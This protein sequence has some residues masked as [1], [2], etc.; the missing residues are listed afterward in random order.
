M[1]TFEDIKS[2]VD[3]HGD[4]GKY[5][6]TRCI[7]HNDNGPSLL[8]FADG[9]FRCL[10]CN[11]A[12]NWKQLWGKLR[13]QPITISVEKGTQWKGVNTR[14][15]NLEE[16]CYRSH[17]HLQKFDSFAYYIQTRGLVD[18]IDLYEIGYFKGWYTIP[19]RDEQGNFITA[20]F[21]AAPHV[22]EASGM[23]YVTKSAPVMYVPDW[24]L[25]RNSNYLCVVY[26]MFDA[27]T[28]SLLGIPAVTSTGG[29]DL[30]NPEWLDK[31]RKTILV[32]PDKGEEQTAE[33][34]V[35]NL[36]WR[37]KKVTLNYPDGKKDCTGFME[38][39]KGQD[40]YKQILNWRNQYVKDKVSFGRGNKSREWETNPKIEHHVPSFK[41]Q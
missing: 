21:R 32:I 35:R 7:F 24:N 15:L 41:S 5:I 14:N 38:L 10:G 31:I 22:A 26:G 17:L 18:A 6:S 19:V 1:L 2:R 16:L 11:R 30:F 37:G 29:K 23:R 34:L 28:L 3:I 39:G 13:G 12:G 40:L 20:V 36:G 25:V 4:Y 9:W 8:I 33:Q 27:I